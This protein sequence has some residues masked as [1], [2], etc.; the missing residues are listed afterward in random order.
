VQRNLVHEIHHMG[1]SF[2]Q[3]IIFLTQNFL[4]KGGALL[5]KLLLVTSTGSYIS[6]DSRSYVGVFISDILS[7]TATKKVVFVIVEVG[8]NFNYWGREVVLCHG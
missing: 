8:L 1:N 6:A 3:T 2:L 4:C 7:I 5:S